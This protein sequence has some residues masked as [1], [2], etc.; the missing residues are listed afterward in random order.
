MS[1]STA[2]YILIAVAVL[3]GL[4]TLY[5]VANGIVGWALFS[6]AICA[7]CCYRLYSMQQGRT[8]PNR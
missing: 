1:P 6:G 4:L 8:R 2:R 3:S 7:Y 5:R